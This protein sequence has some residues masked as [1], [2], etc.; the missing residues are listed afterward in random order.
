MQVQSE[1]PPFALIAEVREGGLI[2]SRFRPEFLPSDNAFR[3]VMLTI[4]S[5]ASRE[6]Y[7]GATPIDDETLAQALERSLTDSS[8]VRARVRILSEINDE[9]GVT[10]ASGLLLEALPEISAA[11]FDAWAKLVLSVPLQQLFTEVA[12]GRFAGE[13]IEL[14]ELIDIEYACTCSVAR[15]EQTLRSLG[16]DDLEALLAEQGQ[17]E[18]DCHFCNERY[19]IDAPRLQQIIDELRQG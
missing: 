3:G 14:L 8:Q 13:D 19:V 2:R 6:L 4:K 17:A 1:K 15:I 16:A 12:F 10:F 11:D 5:I 9:G 18:A 7:R